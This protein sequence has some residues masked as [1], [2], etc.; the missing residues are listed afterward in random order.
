MKIKKLDPHNKYLRFGFGVLIFILILKFKFP[1]VLG[2]IIGLI[3]AFMLLLFPSDL[4]ISIL[5][6]IFG[7]SKKTSIIMKNEAEDI[8]DEYNKQK[9]KNKV[10]FKR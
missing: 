10:K 5:D 2:I 3:Q 8:T 4:G 7:Y 1:F 6:K 9:N